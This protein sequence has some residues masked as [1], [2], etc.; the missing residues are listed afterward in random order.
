MKFQ[1]SSLNSF[2]VTVGTKKCDPRTQARS[3]SNMPHQIFQCWGHKNTNLQ[4]LLSSVIS[5]TFNL[6]IFLLALFVNKFLLLNQDY[7]Q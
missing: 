3:K 4:Y 1:G 5:V 6:N 7:L 2:K